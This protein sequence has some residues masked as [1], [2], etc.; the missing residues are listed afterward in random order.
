MVADSQTQTISLIY[1]DQ[2]GTDFFRRGIQV[3]RAE[4]ARARLVRVE[5]ARGQVVRG[6]DEGA[7]IVRGQVVRRRE[8]S[9][10]FA[11]ITPR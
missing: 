7:D 1:Q 4:V 5:A 8:P 2:R 3:V 9:A 11:G 10:S 6:Q